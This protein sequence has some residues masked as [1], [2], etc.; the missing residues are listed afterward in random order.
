MNEHIIIP[1]DIYIVSETDNYG[2]ITSVNDVF[3]LIS[4]YTSEEII[5]KSHNIIRHPDT[6][7]DIFTSLWRDILE[8]KT[9]RG[10]LKNMTKDGNYYWVYAT[11]S[12][13][14]R[15]NGVNGYTSIRQAMTPREITLQEAKYKELNTLV[16]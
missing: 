8:G 15:P 13:I 3:C 7:K 4:G 10:F 5:G 12:P 6:P 16:L 14:T 1:K 11:V 9:W 2:I